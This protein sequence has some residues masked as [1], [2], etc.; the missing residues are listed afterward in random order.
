[1]TYSKDLCT[2]VMTYKRSGKSLEQ[3]ASALDISLSTVIRI[4]RCWK[5]HGV[6]RNPFAGMTG[7]KRK[8]TGEIIDVCSV[9]SL[10]EMQYIRGT[11]FVLKS[12]WYLQEICDEIESVRLGSF[13]ASCP[14]NSPSK[15]FP[16]IFSMSYFKPI[17]VWPFAG[18]VGFL[19]A[20]KLRKCP[21]LFVKTTAIF[22]SGTMGALVGLL[23]D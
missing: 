15:A 23:E 5:N 13:F 18:R 3:T 9:D 11:L 4:R 17:C 6:V 7:P 19:M 2:R 20:T 10:T 21:L 22:P 14:P 8:C 12:D 1:M 16:E